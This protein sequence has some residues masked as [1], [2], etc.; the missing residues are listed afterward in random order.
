[1]Y[2]STNMDKQKPQEWPTV[3]DFKNSK[4]IK[5]CEL[6]LGIYIQFKNVKRK[7][8]KFGISLIL[9]LKS[10]SDELIR[11]WSLE[12]L[13][14]ELLSE[15]YQYVYNEGLVKSEKTGNNY[16]KFTLL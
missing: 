8:T 2:I 1:M 13:T 7:K 14:T 6:P 4:I 16:F 10:K 9:P 5:W 15:N 3:E 11:V 12:K